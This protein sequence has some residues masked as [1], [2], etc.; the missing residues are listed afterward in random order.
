MISKRGMVFYISLLM[1]VFTLSSIS[2]AE[3]K[4]SE[5][6]VEPNCPVI[7][8]D[9]D[10]NCSEG[11]KLSITIYFRGID[12]SNPSEDKFRDL[13]AAQDTNGATLE[14]KCCKHLYWSAS[15]NSDKDVREN[16]RMLAQE[17][18]KLI[19]G[20]N[21]GIKSVNIHLIGFSTGGLVAIEAASN[22]PSQISSPSRNW[23]GN[24]LSDNI[25]I[26]I[27]IVT[28]ATPY[29]GFGN[30]GPQFAEGLCR[31]PIGKQIVG[32][33]GGSVLAC[34]VGHQDYG[35]HPPPTNLCKF[36]AL[37]TE[38]GENGDNTA[39]GEKHYPDSKILGEGWNPNVVSIGKV[40]H[41]EAVLKAW[42]NHQN[43]FTPKCSCFLEE[44]TVEPKSK[45]QISIIT[46]ECLSNL[47]VEDKV[48]I[49]SEFSPVNIFVAITL[50]VIILFSIRKNVRAK[51]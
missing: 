50:S 37:V 42:E 32:L 33:F 17:I 23:C 16:G 26:E 24:K 30:F 9:Q 19:E 18:N 13:I 46:K 43:L 35:G 22:I 49:A 34:S 51:K 6:G 31:L 21:N 41:S 11:V 15:Y 36:T 3:A 25:P 38:R 2:K 14:S 10:C 47:G 45:S 1:L 20:N 39:G 12:E 8:E 44:D 4:T 29:G 40:N 28:I 7:I 48:I 27:D 5:G